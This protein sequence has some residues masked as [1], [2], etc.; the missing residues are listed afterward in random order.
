MVN[1]NL[2][3]PPDVEPVLMKALARNVGDRYSSALEFA[4]EL[5]RAARSKAV[6]SPAIPSFGGELPA[7][8]PAA[9]V[10]SNTPYIP[11]GQSAPPRSDK[12]FWIGMAVAIVILIIL[13]VIY[14]A[15][16]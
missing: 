11:Q 8:S 3:L 12:I 9:P 16:T 7:A 5:E 14:M 13:I 4:Q 1:N 10:Y 2:F 6:T 15:I